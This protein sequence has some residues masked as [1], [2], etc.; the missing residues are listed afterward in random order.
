MKDKNKQMLLGLAIVAVL[1]VLV[2][3]VVIDNIGAPAD[4]WQTMPP[5]PQPT[6]MQ[7][8]T[9]QQNQPT[10]VPAPRSAMDVQDG[11]SHAV[12]RIRPSVVAVFS[13]DIDKRTGQSGL[14]YIKPYAGAFI[15]VR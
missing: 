2:A 12:S 5:L 11:I 6:P 1:T 10:S 8:P 4:T 13:P 14:A 9:W 15:N 3:F 7:Q